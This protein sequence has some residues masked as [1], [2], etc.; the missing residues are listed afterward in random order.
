[1]Q[2]VEVSIKPSNGEPIVL[3]FAAGDAPEAAAE[4]M[5]VMTWIV[6]SVSGQPAEPKR[7]ARQER[8]AA[9]S[10]PAVEP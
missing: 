9:A 7:R 6:R 5:R 10:E 1:M 2:S 3:V 4:R 8:P